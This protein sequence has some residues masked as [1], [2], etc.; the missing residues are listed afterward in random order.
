M[1]VETYTYP[2]R[3]GD[4]YLI[5]SDGLTGMMPE[6]RVAE[7]L[8]SRSS[9]EQAAE[10]AGGRRERARREGQHHVVLFKLGEEADAP[11]GRSPT[12]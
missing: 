12:R 6:E 4:V 1:E 11:P 10:G 5:C 7:I 2:A 3:D 9:L 8:R